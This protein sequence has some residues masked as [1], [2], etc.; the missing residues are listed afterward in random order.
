MQLGVY[1]FNSLDKFKLVLD[2]VSESSRSLVLLG[3][4]GILRQIGLTILCAKSKTYGFV[5]DLDGVLSHN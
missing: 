3:F 1:K 2:D 5:E 4:N